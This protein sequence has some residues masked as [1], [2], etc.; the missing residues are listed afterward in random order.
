MEASS[1]EVFNHGDVS[2]VSR[3]TEGCKWPGR[4]GHGGPRK[5]GTITEVGLALVLW[6]QGLIN[7]RGQS[8]RQKIEYMRGD[9]EFRG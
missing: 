4:V 3:C 5:D 8:A 6:N 7:E 2:F 9:K 1:F